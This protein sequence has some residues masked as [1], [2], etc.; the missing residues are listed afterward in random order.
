MISILEEE[1][2]KNSSIIE[3]LKLVPA[4]LHATNEQW[5]CRRNVEWRSEKIDDYDWHMVREIVLP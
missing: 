1:E 4:P 3:S 2:T 5:T